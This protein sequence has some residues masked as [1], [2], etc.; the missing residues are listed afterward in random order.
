ME[1]FL[2]A[3]W[4]ELVLGLELV[5]LSSSWSWACM[6]LDRLV[7]VPVWP[8]HHQSSLWAHSKGYGW[9]TWILGIQTNVW[10]EELHLLLVCSTLLGV[11]MLSRTF[12]TQDGLF[13]LGSC[14][15]SYYVCATGLSIV[16]MEY[17]T[18]WKWIQCFIL[19]KF[20]KCLASLQ[21][22]NTTGVFFITFFFFF[23]FWCMVLHCASKHGKAMHILKNMTEYLATNLR[24]AN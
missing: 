12:K 23:F 17:K 8:P 20:R 19:V 13:P 10:I 14:S 2:Q 5:S 24:K 1:V 16:L 4:R 15:F 6:G 9:K 7:L 21:F 22:Y 3:Y 18:S 11:Y